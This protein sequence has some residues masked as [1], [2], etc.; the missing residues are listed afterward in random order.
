MKRLRS[1]GRGALVAVAAVCAVAA[2]AGAPVLPGLSGPDGADRPAGA[3]WAAEGP[4]PYAFD[5]EADVIEGAE[6]DGDAPPLD[7]GVTYRDSIGPGERL[8]YLI[9]L[10]AAEN[11]YVSATAVPALGSRVRLGDELTVTVEDPDGRTC[12]SEEARVPPTGDYPRPLTAYASRTLDGEESGPCTAAG[13]YRVVVE[14]ESKA[15]STQDPWEMELRRLSEPGLRSGG[16]TEPAGDWSS[17]VPEPPSAAPEAREGGA[18]FSTA[19]GLEAGAWT[20]SVVP[21]E[22]VFYRVPVDW[23]QQLFATA[24]LGSSEGD[25]IV[26]G[27]MSLAVHNPARG[28]VDSAESTSYSG[29]PKSVSTDPAPP[30]DYANRFRSSARE[31]AMRFAGWYYVRVSLNPEVGEK[32]GQRP[33]DVTLSLTVNG[34]A[35]DGPEYDGP[36]GEFAVSDESLDQAENGDTPAAGDSGTMKLVA[37]GGIGLGTVLLLGLGGWTLLARRRA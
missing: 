6:S 28:L 19:V 16:P 36:A 2:Q 35:V 15:T 33:Y 10:D 34:A 4:S 29:R 11:A 26:G 30:V 20:A 3:A 13:T 21:G 24:E 27:A 18:G 23:G 32:F 37:A 12:D 7:E 14:R 25:G 31:R 8:H 9:D 17:A 1:G 5:P 22:S